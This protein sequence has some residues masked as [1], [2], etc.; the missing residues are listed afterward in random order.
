MLDMEKKCK[1]HHMSQI[2]KVHIYMTVPVFLFLLTQHFNKHHKLIISLVMRNSW[3]LHL[4]M[5]LLGNMNNQYN[6]S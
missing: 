6:N 5:I 1:T 4:L 2:L 3:I